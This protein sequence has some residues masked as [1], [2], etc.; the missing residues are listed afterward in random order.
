[1][2]SLIF[3]DSYE[4]FRKDRS[5]LS[6]TKSNGGGVLLAVRKTLLPRELK[7]PNTSGIEIVWVT[8]PAIDRSIHIC[9]AYL[10]P[11]RLNDPEL[12]ELYSQSILWVTSKMKPKDSI[13]V[14]GDFNLSCLKWIP[15]TSGCLFVDVSRSTVNSLTARFLDDHNL[16]NLVQI[17]NIVNE[18][19]AQLDL[20]FVSND[21][22]DQ[23]TVSRAPASL[24]RDVRHHPPLHLSIVDSTPCKFTDNKAEMFY[25]F[26][27]ADFIGMNNFLSNVNWGELLSTSDVNSAALTFSHIM[28][29]AIDQFV[30]KKCRKPPVSPEW[31]TPALK[32]LKSTKRSVLKNFS[33]FH[34][35]FYRLQFNRI[36]HCY[37]RL[38]KKLFL[39]HQIRIQKT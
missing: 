17:S 35:S 5:N 26:K 27:N 31:S 37:K 12:I 30:P 8:L 23:F 29:Y 25:T 39:L 1:M 32:R 11:D 33:K 13:C 20:C 34:S 24:V 6:S 28:L 9:V 19:N 3:D 10:P 22:T 15:D 18:N 7:P 16:A 38:N 2:S 21:V 4:V 14:L 36:N